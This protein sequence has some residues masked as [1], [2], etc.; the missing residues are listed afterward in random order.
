MAQTIRTH[1]YHEIMKLVS[2]NNQPF[3][4]NPDIDSSQ[5]QKD[6]LDCS[7]RIHIKEYQ[8]DLAAKIKHTKLS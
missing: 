3:N 6:E 2:L 7:I 8:Q 5:K 4:Y 1:A